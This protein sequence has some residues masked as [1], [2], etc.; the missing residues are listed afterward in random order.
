MQFFQERSKLLT[1]PVGMLRKT[2]AEKKESKKIT[3]T[4]PNLIGFFYTC[5]QPLEHYIYT[6]CI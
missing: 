5:I 1:H 2:Y 3:P 6:G 4:I